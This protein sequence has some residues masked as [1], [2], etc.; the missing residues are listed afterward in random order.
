MSTHAFRYF[1][2]FYTSQGSGK[3]IVAVPNQAIIKIIPFNQLNKEAYT[4]THCRNEKDRDLEKRLF[5]NMFEIVL[6][7]DYEKIFRFREID[8]HQQRDEY[9]AQSRLRISNQGTKPGSAY[10]TL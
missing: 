6:D 9:G 10:S 1:K 3:P 5:D 2:N 4:K 7:Q 8:T